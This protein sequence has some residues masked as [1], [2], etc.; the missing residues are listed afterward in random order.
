MALQ[1]HASKIVLGAVAVI[2]V[3][4]YARTRPPQ[5]AGTP[6]ANPLQTPGVANIEGAYQKGGAT[7][8][9]TKAYGGTKLGEKSDVL[10]DDGGTGRSKGVDFEGA[11]DDQRPEGSRK[12]KVAE[13]FDKMKYGSEKDK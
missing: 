5:P 9:H 8:T 6:T 3:A 12:G 2:G 4:T 1:K 10:K 13:K 11:G 7:A